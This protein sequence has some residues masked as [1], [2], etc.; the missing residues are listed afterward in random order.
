VCKEGFFGERA[1]EVSVLLT[2]PVDLAFEL[3]VLQTY[4]SLL[5]HL[6][7]VWV[8]R[9]TKLEDDLVKYETAAE[10]RLKMVIRY[11]IERKK[12]FRS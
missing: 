4:L 2:R 12:I 3:H 8:E 6:N 9:D 11:R 7:S 1:S 5:Q 10:W